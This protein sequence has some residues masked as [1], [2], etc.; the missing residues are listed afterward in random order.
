MPKNV[1]HISEKEAASTNLETLLAHVRAGTEVIIENGARPVA[2]LHPAEPV[3]RTD[4]TCHAPFE[5]R[6]QAAVSARDGRAGSAKHG[7]SQPAGVS[8]EPGITLL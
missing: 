1:I 8:G 4:S 5:S 7:K 2:V 3:D 6:D